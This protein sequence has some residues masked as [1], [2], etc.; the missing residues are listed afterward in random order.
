MKIIAFLLGI[1]TAWVPTLHS[2]GIFFTNVNSPV[3]NSRENIRQALK[4]VSDLGFEGG[5]SMCLEQ[6]LRFLA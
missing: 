2:E 3:Y 4:V 5:V 1:L 6:E